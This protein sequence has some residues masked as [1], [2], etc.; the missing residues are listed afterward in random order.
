MSVSSLAKVKDVD[1]KA[2]REVK[3]KFFYGLSE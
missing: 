2:R 1:R 3:Q